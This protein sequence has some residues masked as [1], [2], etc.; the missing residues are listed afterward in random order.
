M[1]TS[2]SQYSIT[3]LNGVP[4]SPSMQQLPRT[5]TKGQSSPQSSSPH[6]ASR[7]SMLMAKSSYTDARRSI[8]EFDDTSQNTVRAA[9]SSA[10]NRASN[11]T[12]L[13][14][15]AMNFNPLP[16]LPSKSMSSRSIST[17]ASVKTNNGDTQILE[18]ILPILD[19][20]QK[21]CK[22]HKSLAAMESLQKSL[23]SVER[24]LPGTVKT[25]FQEV[26]QLL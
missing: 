3:H 19:K 6:P 26:S 13:I 15:K 9:D 14:Q 24:E 8:G 1:Q 4:S 23:I 2:P 18:T 25:L 11:R 20:L 7:V 5:T 21:N 10:N 22:N 12:S 17:I 16:Q